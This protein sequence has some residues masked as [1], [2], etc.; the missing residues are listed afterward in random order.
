MSKLTKYRG[1]V[2][3]TKDDEFVYEDQMPS[4]FNAFSDTAKALIANNRTSKTIETY[5]S[6]IVSFYDFCDKNNVRAIPA[7]PRTVLAFISFQSEHCLSRDGKQFAVNTIATRLA[8]IKFFHNQNGYMSPTDHKMNVDAFDGLKRLKGR[9]IKDT[10]QDP[11]MYHE[12]EMII[13]AI[14]PDVNL[15]A[16][17]D[18]AIVTLG[19]QGGFRRS[20]LCSL[21]IKDI[22]FRRD[23]LRIHLLHSKANQDNKLEWKELPINEPFSAYYYVKKWLSEAELTEGN[24]FRTLTRDKK[25][26]RTYKEDPE[27]KQATGL[28]SGNDIYRLIKHYALKAGLPASKIGAH[29]LRS[30]CVTQLAENDKNDIYI[31]GR[32]GHQDPR[33]LQNYIKRGS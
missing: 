26:I 8:A 4:S 11:I 18:K 28:M 23:A 29:S 16:I 15:K 5:E 20:E 31:M 10:R 7:D 30:G 14:G 3:L 9:D 27:I 22:S 33:T 19:L 1:K 24:V 17:R 21:L 13:K 32:T 12:L 2:A 6:N 25:S